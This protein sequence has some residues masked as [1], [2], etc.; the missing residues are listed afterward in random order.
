MMNEMT[1]EDALDRQLREAAPYID[2]DGF[3]ARVVAKLPAVRRQRRST[4]GI[5]LIGITALGSAIAYTLS[6]GGRFVNEGVMRLSGF[7]I[8]LLLVFAFGCGLII[9]AGAVIWAIRRTPEVRDL[10]RLQS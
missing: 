9:G 7:P 2:D 5:I 1:E 6:G 10:T 8:W 4:R 3:T